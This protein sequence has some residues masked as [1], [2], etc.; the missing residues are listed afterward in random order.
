MHSLAQQ[1][2]PLLPGLNFIS[3]SRLFLAYGEFLRRNMSGKPAAL[4][5]SI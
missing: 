3:S 4:P 1:L 5:D 2:Y